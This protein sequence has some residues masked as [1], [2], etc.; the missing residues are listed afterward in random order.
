VQ[1]GQLVRGRGKQHFVQL[2]IGIFHR[3][4]QL[5]E[6]N[7]FP[8]AKLESEFGRSWPMNGTGRLQ[9]RLPGRYQD[10]CPAGQA[11]EADLALSRVKRI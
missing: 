4:F 6:V 5:F 7:R 8:G 9:T 2:L 10:C 3:P 11:A 1:L